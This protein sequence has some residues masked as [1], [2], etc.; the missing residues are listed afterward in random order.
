MTEKV[1]QLA[2]EDLMVFVLQMKLTV[3]LY[4]GT[5]MIFVEG[6]TFWMLERTDA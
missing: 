5:E 4:L 3:K 2:K 6:I 1:V